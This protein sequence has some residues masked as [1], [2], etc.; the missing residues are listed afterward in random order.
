M[1]LS[2]MN[3]FNSGGPREK[4][5]CLNLFCCFL[6]CIRDHS[7]TVYIGRPLLRYA[8][9]SD[10]RNK[11]APEGQTTKRKEQ[12][13]RRVECRNSKTVQINPCYRGVKTDFE[14]D[15]SRNNPRF[16]LGYG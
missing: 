13:D 15:P 3:I 9:N 1:H 10:Q 12:E 11:R 7:I 4:N 5:P 8:L 2:I 14:D 6:Q 16:L